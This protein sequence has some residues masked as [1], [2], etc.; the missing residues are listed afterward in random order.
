MLLPPPRVD[1]FAPITSLRAAAGIPM[2]LC[3]PPELLFAILSNGLPSP[4]CEE[5][6]QAAAGMASL[7]LP[8]RADTALPRCLCLQPSPGSPA[9]AIANVVGE[10]NCAR[11]HVSRRR[12]LRAQC[13]G[14]TL[15]GERTSKQ[16]RACQHP[17][18]RG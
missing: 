13:E 5:G 11:N 4:G 9:S 3:L 17:S 7:P 10:D 12:G 8:P 6:A 16:T 1:F 14:G 18:H 2:R 15:T